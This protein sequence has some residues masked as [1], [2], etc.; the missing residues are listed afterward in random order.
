MKLIIVIVIV[1]IVIGNNNNSGN[2]N[3]NDG[4]VLLTCNR[5]ANQSKL[6]KKFLCVKIACL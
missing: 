1:V 2:D 3:E 6:G 5:V 4:C